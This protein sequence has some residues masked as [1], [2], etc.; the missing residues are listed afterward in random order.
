MRLILFIVAIVLFLWA[1]GVAAGV[2]DY[3]NVV[4]LA[5]LGAVAF[6]VA[7]VSAPLR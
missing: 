5:L 6:V 2:V 4:V 3:G 7:F 1:A